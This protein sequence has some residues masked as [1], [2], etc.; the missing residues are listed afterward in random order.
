MPKKLRKS[1][2]KK[3][4][5]KPIRIKLTT[6]QKKQAREHILKHGAA[7]FEIKEIRVKSA[8]LRVTTSTIHNR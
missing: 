4:T 1:S 3:A 5:P 2:G 8:P 6:T 7:K